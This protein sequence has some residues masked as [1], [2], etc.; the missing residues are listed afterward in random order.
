M[1][2]SFLLLPGADLWFDPAFLGAAEAAQC[3]AGLA[4]TVAWE[5]RSI[6]L[7][8]RELPQPRLTAWH[9]DPGAPYTYSG[10]RWEPRP[11][12]PALQRL[13]RAVETATAPVSTACC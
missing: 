6:R 4:A 12:T 1:P 8:G 5:Q 11:W 7:Y 2:L 3:P 9:G 13:R 10:L